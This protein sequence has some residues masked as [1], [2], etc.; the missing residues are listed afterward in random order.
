MK[1]YQRGFSL[2]ELLVVIAIIAILVSLL[3][4]AVQAA[5]EA[6]RRMQC[7]NN[8]K[9]IG[10]AMHNY[11]NSH[12]TLP[13]GNF[14]TIANWA[15][16]P[17]CS[18]QPVGSLGSRQA[19]WMQRILPYIDQENLYDSF[20]DQMNSGSVAAN[21]Y[22]N[23]GTVIPTLMCPSD[24]ANPKT[25]NIS[26]LIHFSGNYVM[27]AGSQYW[28]NDPNDPCASLQRNGLFYTVSKV[29]FKDVADGLSNTIM[30]SELVLVPDDLA[31]PQRDWRG[32]Y[33][34]A[35]LGGPLFSTREPPF[36]EDSLDGACRNVPY[37]PCD[38]TNGDVNI[39][40]RSYHAAGVNS[41]FGDG[42]VRVISESVDQSVYQKLGT[43]AGREVV[44]VGD[45]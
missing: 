36:W 26:A 38:P 25:V 4:P 39:H 8:L 41:V 44:A 19:S 15:N 34:Q 33:Y 3:L 40:A 27:C 12:N 9:Q 43:R 45:H 42:A 18:G 2:I 29:Q 17:P 13:P 14:D 23:A 1:R 30:G 24:P 5:R 7:R 20:V 16:L 28:G 6:A 32:R 22:T 21:Q 10:I 37:A 31:T 35:L 11:H